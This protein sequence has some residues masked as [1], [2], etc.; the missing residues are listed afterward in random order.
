M[1]QEIAGGVALLALATLYL[2]G[3]AGIPQS[4]L[5]DEIGAR[6]MPYL[7]GV[8]LAVVSV[9]IIARGAL[10]PAAPAANDDEDDYSASMLRALGVFACALLYIGVAWLAGYIVA[11]AVTLLAV[12]L[13]EGA[14]LDSRVV[15]VAVIGALFFWLFFV[16][17]LG[18]EQPIGK[19]F[20]A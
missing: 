7:I 15:A 8:L 10:A 20:G 13:Y 19:L 18:V 6:G 2:I 17:F 5:S 16:Y 1:K 3:A 12:M 4:T 11:S 9:A 14:R